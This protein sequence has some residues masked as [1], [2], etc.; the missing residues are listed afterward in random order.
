MTFLQKESGVT[1]LLTALVPC[2]LT[3]IGHIVNK[4]QK[5][6]NQEAT[7]VARDL[8]QKWKIIQR[9]EEKHGSDYIPYSVN[10]NVTMIKTQPLLVP[11]PLPLSMKPAI[12][13]RK[14]RH[15]CLKFISNALTSN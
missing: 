8:N 4:L 9:F 6:E 7:A 11:H 3:K 15:R 14:V 13:H 5:S 1:E 10:K 12:G 2:S